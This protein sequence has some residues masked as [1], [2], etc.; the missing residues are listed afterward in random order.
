MAH[1]F[2]GAPISVAHAAPCATECAN[3]TP[4]HTFLWRT[5]HG[6]PQ[7]VGLSVAHQGRAPQKYILVARYLWRTHQ[8]QGCATDT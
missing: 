3:V 1:N 5:Q 4:A 7:I 8:A 6:A 2:C